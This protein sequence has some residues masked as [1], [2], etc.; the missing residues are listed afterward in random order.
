MEE[1]NYTQSVMNGLIII[2]SLTGLTVIFSYIFR[3]FIA[4]N[5]TVAD[6]GLFFSV[7][8]LVAFFSIF[9]DFGFNEALVRF[10][11]MFKI[12]N[13]KSNLKYTILLVI[14]VTLLISLLIVISLIIFSPLIAEKYLYTPDAVPIIILIA[15]SF[16][17]AGGEWFFKNT[18]QGYQM[19]GI[20]SSINLFRAILLLIFSF[21]FIRWGKGVFGVAYAYILTPT[22]IIII[23]IFI[24]IKKAEPDFFKIRSNFNIKTAYNN[25]LSKKLRDFAIPTMLGTGAMVIITYTDSIMLTF[26]SGVFFVGLYNVALPSANF[27]GQIVLP[28]RTII[29]PLSSELWTKKEIFKL[30]EG[31]KIVYKYLFMFLLPIIFIFIAFSEE[32]I[33]ILFGVKYIDA[34]S[35]LKILSIGMFLLSFSQINYATI[36]GIGKPKLNT[37][38]TIISA[39]VNLI[40]NFI[41]IPIYGIIGAAT[42]TSTSYLIMAIIS[43]IYIRRFIPMK[44]PITKWLKNMVAGLIF[45]GLMKTLKILIITNIYL[46]LILAIS[47]SGIIYIIMIFL[48]R[49]ISIDEIKLLVKTYKR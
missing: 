32:I 47:I 19:M 3:M 1:K 25:P 39:I 28:L 48:L 29:Y 14:T 35:P 45:F 36:A 31:I 10:I 27:I 5:L 37:Y 2:I 12:K 43:N 42:A 8:S 22:I 21:I 44:L 7:F 9:R 18:F 38:A 33:T 34:S 4:R 16:F 23:Y 46:E 15:I 26:F 49:L 41:L 6:Y 17:I 24:F 30:S 20:F 11:P 40:L 13:D